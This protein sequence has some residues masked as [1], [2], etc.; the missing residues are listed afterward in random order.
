MNLTNKIVC[1]ALC[2]AAVAFSS[3]TRKAVPD[4]E[5][6]HVTSK[7]ELY[8]FLD[9]LEREYERAC[10][11]R[12]REEWDRATGTNP[13]RP[14]SSG[15]MFK[16]IF[17][18]TAAA[19][20]L[21]EWRAQSSSLADKPLARRLELW[22]RCFMGGRIETDPAINRLRDS[23]QRA[24]S[25]WTIQ[26]GTAVVPLT[27]L[28]SALQ[29]EK[30]QTVRKSI[31]EAQASLS[32]AIRP[33]L[34]RLIKAQ[35]AAAQKAGFPNYISLFLYLRS[36][37]EEWLLKTLTMIEEQ[38]RGP[39]EEFVT[40][41]RKKLR[42]K[43]MGPWDIDFALRDNSSLPERFFPNDSVI[44]TIQSFD[45]LIGFRTD[46]LPIH[47]AV[48]NIPNDGISV[49]V[50]IPADI[51][52][53][54]SGNDGYET[55]AAAAREYGRALKH[56]L[57]RV[58]YPIQ[59]G[60]PWIPGA[61]C[62]AFDDGLAKMHGAFTADSLWLMT[63]TKLKTRQVQHFL[64][65]RQT[66][67]L[68]HLR[69]K[70]KDFALGYELYK[71]PDQD[72]GPPEYN[73]FR[74]FLVLETDSTDTTAADLW[75]AVNTGQI[76]NAIISDMASAQL[77]EALTSKFG[78]QKLQDSTIGA[79]ITSHLYSMGETLEWAERMRNATGKSLEP[80]AYLRSLGIEPMH[81]IT[82]E[83]DETTPRENSDT[84][85]RRNK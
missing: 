10:M 14:D 76:V 8:R 60:Y 51:M 46:T 4:P 80:G 5:R 16:N 74:K 7:T 43:K 35:N 18:D 72:P 21:T 62:P 26:A 83:S 17:D 37:D 30:K 50:R 55:Y 38:T 22:H 69:M 20:I 32:G 57:T 75:T 48:M 12:G 24:V 44:A 58:E 25:C 2:I 81:L 27:R 53:A 29:S 84:I 19:A 36:I 52:L 1:C 56:A 70:L 9:T 34:I 47:A 73:L 15:T 13:S 65:G 78:E 45:S 54:V 59:K 41:E 64:A 33:Q 11:M 77:Q 61:R 39:V 42:F 63:Y 3:C 79:W 49:P 40:A 28:S 71:N 67:A 31:W 85:D 68:L 66:P 6:H 23:V 82:R